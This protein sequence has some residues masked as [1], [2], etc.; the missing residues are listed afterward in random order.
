MDIE[1]STPTLDSSNIC[2]SIALYQS[3]MYKQ[4]QTK[5]IESFIKLV[6]RVERG[7]RDEVDTN[8]MG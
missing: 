1:A 8:A 2:T 4:I 3:N 5:T 6:S 7:W